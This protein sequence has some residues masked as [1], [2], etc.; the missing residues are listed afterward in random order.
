[1]QSKH[2]PFSSGHNERNSAVEVVMDGLRNVYLSDINKVSVQ[3]P[4]RYIEITHIPCSC[5]VTQKVE[6]SYGQ[7]LRQERAMS[8]L[9]RCVRGEN[10][11]T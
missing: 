4:L 11:V 9:F 5:V 7:Y 1:M 3:E 8:Q 6:E 2:R 10:A